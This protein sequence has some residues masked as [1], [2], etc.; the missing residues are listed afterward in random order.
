MNDAWDK[1]VKWLFLFA[2][3]YFLG[4]MVF[5]VVQYVVS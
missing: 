4:H 3:M 2:A 1:Y 5:A